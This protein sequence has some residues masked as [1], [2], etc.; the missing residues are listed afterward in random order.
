M[1]LQDIATVQSIIRPCGLSQRK[2][3]A[4]IELSNI[5]VEKYGG[6]VPNTFEQL[7]QLPGIGHKTAS[8][9]MTQAF[10][11]PAFPVDTHIQRLAKRW[12]YTESKNPDIVERV[13]KKAFNKKYWIKLHLQ[14]IYYGRN[15]CTARRHKLENCP[16]CLIAAGK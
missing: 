7:E 11:V 16:I 13:L 14:M 8:V 9:V 15:Y 10:S 1:A 4:I 12:G 2:A 3:T 6:V 5:L